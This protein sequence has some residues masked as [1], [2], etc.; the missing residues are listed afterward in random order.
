[1]GG[2]SEGD[3]FAASL[4]SEAICNEHLLFLNATQ[5]PSRIDKAA[6]LRPLPR[7]A[8]Q[9]RDRCFAGTRFR[10]GRCD[11]PGQVQIRPPELLP[12]GGAVRLAFLWC[13]HC[14]PP[15]EI[16]YI[17]IDQP[18]WNAVNAGQW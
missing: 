4:K 18:P 15:W 12:V 10:C 13:R 7:P 8:S 2:G 9:V 3:R 6:H 16:N 1:M 5:Q 14:V 17:P 11:T